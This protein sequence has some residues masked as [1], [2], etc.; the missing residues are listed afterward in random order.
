MVFKSILE[1]REIYRYVVNQTYHETTLAKY[2]QPIYLQFLFTL[3]DISRYITLTKLQF[4]RR[5]YYFSV[6]A[7]DIFPR[8]HKVS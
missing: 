4:H 5:N 6:N 7:T 8:K 3:S 1:I 2:M